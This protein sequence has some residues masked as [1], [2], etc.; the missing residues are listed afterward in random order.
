MTPNTAEDRLRYAK[1]YA[2]VLLFKGDC[3]IGT[4]QLLQLS[5]NKRIHVQKALSCLARFTGKTELW[6]QIRKTYGLTWTTGTE[7]LDAFTRFFSN[8]N[9]LDKMIESLKQARQVLP[10]AYSNILLFCALTG[11]RNSECIECINL[12]R[13]PEQFKIYY[14]ESNQCLE[15]FR[16]K[17]LFLRKTKSAYLTICDRQLLEIVQKL[18]KIPTLNGLKMALRHNCPSMQM[19]WC[20]KIHASF[21]HQCDVPEVIIDLVQGR[22]PRSVLAQHYLLPKPSFKED[23]LRAVHQLKE[24]I[25]S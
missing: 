20:R 25:E 19:K 6:T 3:T 10:K 4:E 21:L 23:V 9:S 22:V 15:H 2:S 13:D 16:F 18:D 14:N 1:Q 8:D 12:I 7:Q 5:P 24:R 11:L 17:E